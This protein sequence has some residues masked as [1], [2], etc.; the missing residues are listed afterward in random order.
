MSMLKHYSLQLTILFVQQYLHLQ[1]KITFLIANIYFL[2]ARTFLNQHPKLEIISILSVL[3]YVLCANQNSV[4][5][6]K[7]KRFYI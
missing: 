4:T 7:E 5:S 2:Q 6:T 1:A 3:H